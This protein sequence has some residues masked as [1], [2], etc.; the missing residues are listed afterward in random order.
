M[1]QNNNYMKTK[2]E[3]FEEK[4]RH[5]GIKVFDNLNDIIKGHANFKKG[6]LAYVRTKSGRLFGPHEILGFI[7]DLGGSDRVVY[8]SK[9]NYMIPVSPSDLILARIIEQ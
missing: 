9:S 1:Y 8:L 7:K 5:K 4:V 6:Q 3:L 2:K